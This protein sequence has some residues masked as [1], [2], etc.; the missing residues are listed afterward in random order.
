MGNVYGASARFEA[1][2]LIRLE[3]FTTRLDGL[4]EIYEFLLVR[5]GAARKRLGR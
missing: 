4:D 2:K 1:A 3:V 5:R